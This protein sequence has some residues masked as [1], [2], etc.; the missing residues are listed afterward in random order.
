MLNKKNNPLNGTSLGKTTFA[1]IYFS[2]LS[3]HTDVLHFPIF[4]LFVPFL[5]SQDERKHDV[6]DRTMQERHCST[7]TIS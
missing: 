6:R 2:I 4:F 5:Y 3:I 1:D 7:H